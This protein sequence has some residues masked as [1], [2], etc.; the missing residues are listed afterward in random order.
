M[1][2]T[3]LSDRTSKLVHSIIS[4]VSHYQLFS[5]QVAAMHG[6][7]RSYS[8][9]PA[10]L[11]EKKMTAVAMQLTWGGFI[12][13]LK[14]DA[15]TALHILILWL[16]C[17]FS[18]PRVCK[19]CHGHTQEMDL[20]PTPTQT[21]MAEW[22]WRSDGANCSSGPIWGSASCPGDQGSGGF[23]MSTFQSLDDPLY[24]LCYSR[25]VSR[26]MMVLYQFCD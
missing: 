8:H 17:E 10:P 14:I 22:S 25:E 4:L 2:C 15:I 11:R 26:V 23:E 24:L 16:T 7:L 20:H 3:V 12:D 1:V 19:H 6:L 9:H 18:H 5:K 21:L 13:V